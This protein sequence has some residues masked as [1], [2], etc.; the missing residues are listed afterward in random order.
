MQV[1][2][3]YEV[4]FKTSLDRQV[5]NVAMPGGVKILSVQTQRERSQRQLCLWALV[6]VGAQPDVVRTFALLGTGQPLDMSHAEQL[7]HLATI[8]DGPY[9]W[10][11]FEITRK[12]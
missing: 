8:Q 1:V 6:D 9:V 3:K 12:E 7:E 11:V 5:F 4:D 2:Y 10:H